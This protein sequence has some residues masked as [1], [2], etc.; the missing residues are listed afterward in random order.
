MSSVQI[1]KLTD[2]LVTFKPSS[3]ESN[4]GV[5]DKFP[6][7]SMSSSSTALFFAKETQL[8]HLSE[9]VTTH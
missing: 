3:L 2:R 7:S 9:S 8:L 5:E 1:T 6:I 4:E